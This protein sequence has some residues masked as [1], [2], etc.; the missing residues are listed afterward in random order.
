M[1]NN[2][3]YLLALHTVDGL[4]PMRLKVLLEYFKD[5]KLAWEADRKQLL[6]IGVPVK[7]IDLLLQ[8][9]QK[10]DPN[11]YLENITKEEIKWVTLFDEN[12]PKRLAQIYDPPI[13]LFYKGEILPEDQK[14][15]AIV[16]SRKMTGYGREVTK[17]FAKELVNSGMTVVS[18]L[19]RGVDSQ[20]H[21]SALEEGGR[22]IAVL[23]GGI[24]F[25]YPPENIGLA[26]EIILHG[27]IIS[28]FPP[29]YPSLP[30]NFPARNRIISG[31]SLATLVTEAAEDSGSLI[32]A[33]VALEQGREVFAI[34]GPIT[35]LL[36]KGP[37]D[38]IKE[39][40]RVVTDPKEIL[41]E[42]GLGQVKSLKL[43]VKNGDFTEEERNILNL[44]QNENMQ[45]DEICRFLNQPTSVVLSTLLKMEITG[46]IKNLG[47]GVYCLF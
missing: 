20:A 39:G 29:E 33:R 32:T 5:P 22:T 2:S 8:T 15:I 17:L 34:P 27:A 26:Q 18:G 10:L 42:L 24:K 35:S 44:L 13:V 6:E 11:Q 28:E 1:M 46:L 12:Y 30:G 21:R 37:I 14:A 19:A 40:A 9:R 43:K 36:S 31:L 16:G 41:E 38:L 4:G 45:I 23:G 3:S 47:N 7:V 25:I